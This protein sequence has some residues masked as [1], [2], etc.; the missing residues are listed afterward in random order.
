MSNKLVPQD[1]D[2]TRFRPLSAPALAGRFLFMP[3][4]PA[5]ADQ[6]YWVRA[7]K[8]LPLW[9]LVIGIFYAV[10]F[11][12]AWRAFGEYQG[13]RWVPV[14]AVLAV[15][16]A[17][18]GYRMLAGAA[19]LASYK[20][21]KEGHTPL[22][23]RGLLVVL[24]IVLGKFSLLASLPIGVWQSAPSGNW[25]WGEFFSKLGVLYPTALYRPLILA[26]IW[27]RWAMTLAATIGRTAPGGSI[28]LQCMAGRNRLLA[29]FVGWL[30]CAI[31]T[32]I[33][34]SGS[35]EYV[36]RGVVLALVAM[37]VAYLTSFTLAL[38][39]GGQSEATVGTTGLVTEMTFLICYVGI[40]NAIYWY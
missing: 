23:L 38:R 20:S 7:T 31:L 14:V 12:L 34:C 16:V 1:N 5:D 22:N 40:S 39:T 27:G 13:I 9:G 15:D 18:C 10:V 3:P 6:P 19:S 29:I 24:L 36:T 26:P 21:D 28:R 8:W 25:G 2:S 32:A 37:V 11:R 4:A 33:Y 17:L 35:G 30:A